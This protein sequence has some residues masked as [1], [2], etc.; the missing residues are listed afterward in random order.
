[1]ANALRQDESWKKQYCRRCYN[2]FT[3]RCKKECNTDPY[4][5]KFFILYRD[6]VSKENN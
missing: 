2:R 5:D 1:M 4:S 6:P 3:P